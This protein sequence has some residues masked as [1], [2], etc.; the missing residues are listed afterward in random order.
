VKSGMAT[1]KA[2]FII[3]YWLS[4]MNFF[5]D[6]WGGCVCE[7]L[8]EK[9]VLVEFFFWRIKEKKK[10]EK[11]KRGNCSLVPPFLTR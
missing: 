6:S 2:I 7:M 1:R 8:K 5:V 9:R 10:E 4:L 3:N 11:E